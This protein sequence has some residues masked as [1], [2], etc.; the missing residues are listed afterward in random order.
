MDLAVSYTVVEG[1]LKRLQELWTESEFTVVFEI[2]KECAEAAGNEL[3]VKIPGETRPRK[4]PARHNYSSKSTVEDQHPENLGEFYTFLDTI[5]QEMVR[6]FKGHD[7][8]STGISLKG[9]HSLTVAWSKG[10]EPGN[11]ELVRTV[12]KFYETEKENVFTDLK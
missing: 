12:S 4:L 6:R 11:V 1:V 5:T 2:A 8:S 10:V 9:L 3:P 7:K